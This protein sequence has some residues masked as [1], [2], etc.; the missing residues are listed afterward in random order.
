MSKGET[1]EVFEAVRTVLAVRNYRP[2]PV[3]DEVVARIVEAGRLTGSSMNAQPWHF[4]VVDDAATLR[5]M[6]GFAQSG[7]YIAQAPLAIVVAVG[8]TPFG[9]SD[10]SRA[11]QSMIL[12]A[13]AE[14]IGSNWVGFRGLEEIRTLLGIPE[15]FEVLAVVPF[16]YPVE[17][18]GHGNKKRKPLEE[19]VSRG[20]YGQA[21]G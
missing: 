21:F 16:G 18:G 2:D 15:E 12:T 4:V 7:P 9:V 1:M 3:P 10:G 8:K 17:P 14:G 11:I 19:V 5:R 20:R 6:G 13:W